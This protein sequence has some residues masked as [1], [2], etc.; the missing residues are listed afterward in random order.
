MEMG[1]SKQMELRNKQAIII[2]GKMDFKPK[3]MIRDKG[4]T[5]DSH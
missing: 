4:G 5:V 3:L 2:F 1:Y